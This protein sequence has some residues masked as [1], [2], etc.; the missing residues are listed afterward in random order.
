MILMR[1]KD[2][3]AVRQAARHPAP[4]VVHKAACGLLGGLVLVAGAFWPQAASALMPPYVYESARKDAVSVILLAVEKV[5]LPRRSFGTCTVDGT[6]ARV[7]RG[8]AYA[9][10]Q[11]VS[12]GVPCARPDSLPPIGGTIYQDTETLKASKFG[13]AYLDADGKVVLSQYEQLGALP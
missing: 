2:R 8:T 1:Q 13:R 10:G 6:V 4:Q 12:I 5:T 7:E 11:Q 9:V 3:R